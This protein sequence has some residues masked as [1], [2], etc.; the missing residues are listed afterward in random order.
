MFAVALAGLAGGVARADVDP[1]LLER[2]VTDLSSDARQGRGLGTAEL[3][4]VTERL[5][6][7]FRAAGLAPGVGSGFIQENVVP[8]I[9]PP[10]GTVVVRNVIGMIKGNAAGSH[11][12]IGAHYDHLGLSPEADATD[13]I[14]NGADDNASGVA[15]LV[16][17][18]TTLTKAAEPP[19]RTI[20]FV[21]FSGE[22]S[23]LL[24][25]KAYVASPVLPIE[26]TV[27]MLNLDSI[28]R[29]TARRLTVL[30]VGTSDLFEPMLNGMN[31]AFRF[32]LALSKDPLHT[33]DHA[34]FVEKSIPSLQLF[35]GG[36][37]DYHRVTDSADKIN[38]EGLAEV[39]ALAAEIIGY[40]SDESVR[41]TFASAAAAAAGATAGTI[42]RR[43]SLG[44]IPDFA[45]ESG[46]VLVSGIVPGSP[47]AQVGIVTGDIVVE[48]GGTAIDNLQDYQAGLA[49]HEP[50]DVVRV[51][52][53]R[54]TERKAFEVTLVAR[55]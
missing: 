14:F 25:S 4:A 21:A 34:P 23:A 19:A 26:E 44:T 8:A 52:V 39:T 13:R 35:T 5:E 7:E 6:S 41:P 29:L 33:S 40:L 51:V 38:F 18:A 54:G 3:D 50:G 1:S 37:A 36:H 31:H 2:I 53:L 22:E 46:G 30:G 27:A 55:K 10:G 45:R 48:F 15:A 28:G 42:R 12:V 24:G 47:A 32:D 17:I 43:A 20:V 16:A 9:D 11:L 49:A